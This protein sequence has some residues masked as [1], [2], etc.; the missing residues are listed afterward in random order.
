VSIL[1]FF[2]TYKLSLVQSIVKE[3]CIFFLCCVEALTLNPIRAFSKYLL[4]I[5]I[6]FLLFTKIKLNAQILE[7]FVRL[8][9]LSYFFPSIAL[10]SCFKAYC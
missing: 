8:K 6:F 7:G 9:V 10:V 3:V 1:P 5:T 4:Q 2:Y